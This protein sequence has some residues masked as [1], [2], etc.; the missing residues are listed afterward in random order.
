MNTRDD[1]APAT[2]SAEMSDESTAL[3]TEPMLDLGDDGHLTETAV[4]ALADGEESLVT[5]RAKAHL[6]ACESCLGRLGDAAALS[7]RTTATID[8]LAKVYSPQVAPRPLPVAAFVVA[9]A[10][11][12]LAAIPG[13]RRA[14]DDLPD[15]AW[16]AR[17]G[18]PILARAMVSV[19]DALEDVWSSPWAALMTAMVLV[20]MGVQVARRS[21]PNTKERNS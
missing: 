2:R 13:L 21:H 10:V 11:A 15:L 4:D 20:M 18:V 9:L 6:D 1:M 12:V 7:E 16:L 5:V 8:D 19:A 17:K 3:T 14:A